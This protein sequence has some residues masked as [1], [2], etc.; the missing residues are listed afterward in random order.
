MVVSLMADTLP[1][2]GAMNAIPSCLLLPWYGEE[3]SVVVPVLWGFSVSHRWVLFP[4]AA[5][6]LSKAVLLMVDTFFLLVLW[7]PFFV[8]CYYHGMEKRSLLLFLCGGVSLSLTC[9]S[10]VFQCRF[11]PLVF[12][13]SVLSLFFLFACFVLSLDGR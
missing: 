13:L 9:P 2:V 5:C 10:L 1:P 3:D 6:P 8:V 12:A 7:M 4:Q 11:L